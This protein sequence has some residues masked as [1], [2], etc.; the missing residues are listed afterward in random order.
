MIMGMGRCRAC[1]KGTSTRA[2][3]CPRCGEPDPAPGLLSR[4]GTGFAVAIA[5]LIFVP[6]VLA[7]S[8]PSPFWGR[9]QIVGFTLLQGVVMAA[10]AWVSFGRMIGRR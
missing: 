8:L 5:A 7:P 9:L 4:V 10:I 6:M 2:R 3:A 1:G